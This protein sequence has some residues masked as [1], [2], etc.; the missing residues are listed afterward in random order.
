MKCYNNVFEK[1]T[2][3]VRRKYLINHDKFV[4]HN[5]LIHFK[6]F[7]SKSHQI[8]MHHFKYFSANDKV[9]CQASFNSVSRRISGEFASAFR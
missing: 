4:K 6:H 9:F 1:E 2:T 8:F 7:T 5:S 3:Y